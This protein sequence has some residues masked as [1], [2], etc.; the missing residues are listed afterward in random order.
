M[1]EPADIYLDLRARL[2]RLDPET[3]GLTAAESPAVFGGVMEIGFPEAVATIAALADGSTSLYLS[4]GG[5]VIGGGDHESV[6]RESVKF[7]EVLGRHVEHLAPDEGDALPA[8]GEVAIRALTRHGRLVATAAEDDLGNDR[9]P[10]SPVFF[11][12]HDV[13][14]ALRQLE[15]SGRWDQ[16]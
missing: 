8:E 6:A 2:L 7:L 15:A 11:A 12:G 5:G 4:T 1:P 13:I 16:P 14:T 10:L 3:V 9:H